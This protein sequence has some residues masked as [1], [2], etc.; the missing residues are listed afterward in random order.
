MVRNPNGFC[1]TDIASRKNL[2]TPTTVGLTAF[3]HAGYLEQGGWKWCKGNYVF[4]L[5][6]SNISDLRPPGLP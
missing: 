4:A 6:K 5:E 1:H 2:R 3:A